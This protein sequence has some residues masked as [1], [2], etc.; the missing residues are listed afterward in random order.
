MMRIVRGAVL[1]GVSAAGKTSVLKAL[2]RG[3]AERDA[4]RSVVILGEHYS[5]ALQRM[6]G[7]RA[8]LPEPEH[9]RLL[10]ERVATLES[11]NRWART[12]ESSSWQALGLFFVLERFH[13][14]HR[15]GYGG[16]EAT[17]IERLE[18][19]LCD[20]GAVCFLL[21]VSPQNVEERIRPRIQG[22]GPQVLQ[23]ASE[24]FLEQQDRL[25][26]AARRSRI[27]T[28]LLSTDDGDWLRCAAFI[29]ERLNRDG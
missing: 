9:R 7:R 20:I 25:L 12:V 28:E 24:K 10:E 22:G 29:L 5:Q 11:L 27:P 23:E 2:K 8:M 26:E 13:L 1:E 15:V 6:G 14:N 21:T 19:R 4:E 17:W 18:D 16:Q 3:Q